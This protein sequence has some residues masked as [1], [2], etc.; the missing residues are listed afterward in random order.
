MTATI[1]IFTEHQA[2]GAPHVHV[3][4]AGPTADFLALGY[5]AAP[6]D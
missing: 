2:C 6:L 4:M 3:V 1:V 5:A